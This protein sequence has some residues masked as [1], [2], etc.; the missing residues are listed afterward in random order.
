MGTR[1]GNTAEVWS[2][3][4]ALRMNMQSSCDDS[5]EEESLNTAIADG[6]LV[7]V[8]LEDVTAKQLIARRNLLLRT[9]TS[10]CLF[11]AG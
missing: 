6:Y 7:H 10:N 8:F 1:I 5:T 9:G 11:V 4:N 2:E 3:G